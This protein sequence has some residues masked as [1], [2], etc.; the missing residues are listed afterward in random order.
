M[1]RSSRRR[2]RGDTRRWAFL[3][4]P[5]RRLMAVLALVVGGVAWGAWEHCGVRGCP[6]V[7]TL[8]AY[9]PGGGSRLLDRKGDLLARLRP[10]DRVVVPLDSVPRVVQDAFVAVEDKRFRSH[11][12]VDWLRVP[13]AVWANLRAGGV[14]QGFSTIT[15]QLARNAFPERLP[16]DERSLGRKLVE[17]RVAGA[18]EDHFSKD[19]ILELYLNSIYFGEGVHG[20]ATASRHYFGTP[21]SKLTLAQGALLAALPK[22]PTSYDPRA[23][24]KAA[25]ARRDLV[26][27]L[28]EEQGKI[29][30]GKAADAREAS[31]GVAAEP[32]PS[33]EAAAPYFI[34]EVRRELEDRL[35][36]DLYA[37]RLTVRTTLDPGVQAALEEAMSAQLRHIES[38][39][40]GRVDAPRFERGTPPSPEGSP[41][42]Q[43]AAAV[44]DARTGD[45]L[46]LMGGRNFHE[47]PF[48]RAVLGMRQLGSAFKPFLYAEAIEA[49]DAPATL[50][51]DSP[52]EVAL[53]GGRVYR[54][55]DFDGDYRGTVTLREALVHS[56]NV[57]AVRVAMDVGLDRVASAAEDAGFHTTG[58]GPALALG[59][60]E[61][62]PL[63]V[64][65]AY[66]AFATLGTRAEPRLVTQVDDEDGT[67]LWRTEPAT[68]P[69]MDPGVAFLV[70]DML[71]DVV[72][73]GTGQTVRSLGVRGPVA[74]K[75][76]TTD[77]GKDA[78]FVGLT[79][80]L[81][82]A[83]WIGFDRPR[84]VAAGATG[85]ALAAPVVAR[86]LAR[87]QRERP[88][89]A[90]WSPPPSVV[91][92][93]YDPA[94]G[95]VLS[96][97]CSFEGARE[98]WFLRATLPPLGCPQEPRGHRGFW[99]KVGGW[100]G[101]IFGGG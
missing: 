29:E 25:R 82:A 41:Y 38:G 47:S 18:I 57:P 79:P 97:G 100:L 28:M 27:R 78:W 101:S 77:D 63:R 55:A 93:R 32:P 83:V 22:A 44:V 2:S 15:M 19:E 98:D 67:V 35:G 1:A 4:L 54:P 70:T 90:P 71:E 85:G 52:Y 9:Q 40:Y 56:L 73:R 46:A 60:A 65:A 7:R 84:R 92:L 95:T 11:R 33:R 89:P 66:T 14:A 26:L 51:E 12:G 87:L 43:G 94:S 8:T 34:E 74:G 3:P 45:V 69:V 53:S 16:A 59:S 96:E 80:D 24:P 5:S 23:H 72:D 76:G 21:P 36:A 68:R 39:A 88:L 99:D 50:V 64:A 91:R 13:G 10:V 31:L 42:L 81:V 6:D 75:T 30:P 62:A 48:D 37:S 49:G 17:M 61:A 20:I 58:T 86:T